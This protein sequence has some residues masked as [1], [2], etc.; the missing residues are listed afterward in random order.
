MLPNIRQEEICTDMLE[1]LVESAYNLFREW[2][3]TWQERRMKLIVGQTGPT[4]PASQ[5]KQT[6]LTQDRC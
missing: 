5:T 3:T 1:A 2:V 6:I 4:D